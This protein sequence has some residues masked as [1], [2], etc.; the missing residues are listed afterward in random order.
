MQ[1][2]GSGDPT[3][4]DEE[5]LNC[6]ALLQEFDRDRVSNNLSEVMQSQEA[7]VDE[8][9]MCR[10]GISLQEGCR[11]NTGREVTYGDPGC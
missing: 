3:W 6:G 11:R 5:D 9:P 2:K 7:A 1:W 8:Y 4:T 10:I